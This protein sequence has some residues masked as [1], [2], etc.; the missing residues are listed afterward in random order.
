MIDTKMT[1]DQL[2]AA[3][4]KLEDDRLKR[5]YKDAHELSRETEDTV[6]DEFQLSAAIERLF[7][8]YFRERVEY[9]SRLDS[10]PEKT[11]TPA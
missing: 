4:A 11:T 5:I 7:W 9:N 6:S 8:D 10:R 3:V 1:K 2:E